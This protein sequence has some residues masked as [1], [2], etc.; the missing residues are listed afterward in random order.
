MELKSLQADTE[1]RMRELFA[2][3]GFRVLISEEFSQRE[4]I[5]AAIQS[6]H[7][8][9]PQ[10]GH[11]SISHTVGAGAVLFHPRFRVGVDIEKAAR[12]QEKVVARVSAPEELSIVRD[13]SHLWVAKEAS[14]KA[15]RHHNQPQTISGVEISSFDTDKNIFTF[16]LTA[17]SEEGLGEGFVLKHSDYVFAFS[18]IKS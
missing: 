2:D 11:V 3:S 9:E 16:K 6:H 13:P 14:F 7:W 4:M 18:F 1:N 15:C 17:S 8:P 5:R 12:I 10:S